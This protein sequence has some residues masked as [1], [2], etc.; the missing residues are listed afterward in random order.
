MH[1]RGVVDMKCGT[2][3]SV[4]TYVYLHRL[5]ERLRGRLTLTCV[6]DE[7]TGGTW[8]AK[9]LVETFPDEFR[10]DCVLN[11]EPIEPE[12]DPLRREGHAAHRDRDRRTPGAH[13]AYTHHEPQR[14]PHRQ[15]A[16]RA[17][18]TRSRTWA[19]A[20][21][22]AVRAAIERERPAMDAALGAGASG[23]LDRVTVSRRA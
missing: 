16:R 21:D 7:E 17:T 1:G 19:F 4:W 6:S 3:A 13:A 10:G 2:A 14:H 9:W 11:G 8:G 15:R 18:S 12:H 20:Q 5:R 23:I 22:E